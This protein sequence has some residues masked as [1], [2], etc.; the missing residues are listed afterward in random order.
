[1]ANVDADDDDADGDDEGDDG[2]DEVDDDVAVVVYRRKE[3]VRI[4]L[5]LPNRSSAETTV[6]FA[7]GHPH[8]PSRDVDQHE[9]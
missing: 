9:L 3:E 7:A 1:M 6:A 5:L 8:Q 2:N 4:H